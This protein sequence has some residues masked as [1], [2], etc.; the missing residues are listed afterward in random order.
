M[1]SAM[2]S[3]GVVKDSDDDSDRLIAGYRH[4][5]LVESWFSGRGEWKEAVKK[6]D[7]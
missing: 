3:Y 4:N 6:S 7:T 5:W 1:S 2:S